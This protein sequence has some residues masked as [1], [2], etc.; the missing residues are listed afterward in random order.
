MFIY[1]YDNHTLSPCLGSFDH[2]MLCMQFSHVAMF[3]KVQD[4]DVM[5]WCFSS[6]IKSW[7]IVSSYILNLVTVCM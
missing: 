5:G 6:L 2:M 4:S 7:Q 1:N 3:Q